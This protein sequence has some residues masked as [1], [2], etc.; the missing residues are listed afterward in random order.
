MTIHTS[1]K[2]SVECVRN[3]KQQFYTASDNTYGYE[4]FGQGVRNIKR[5]FHTVSD[6]T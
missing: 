2:N 1:T 6:N 4:K 5:Q 3:I